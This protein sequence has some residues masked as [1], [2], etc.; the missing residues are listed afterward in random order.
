MEEGGVIAIHSTEQNNK[1]KKPNLKHSFAKPT[2]N[3]SKDK[4]IVKNRMGETR[5][6][7]IVI[8]DE[9]KEKIIKI[10]LNE[11]ERKLLNL[12]T[13]QLLKLTKK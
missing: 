2:P 4:T 9:S 1:R 5:E 10:L 7:K 13:Q 12:D 3:M 6:K 11:T 8:H